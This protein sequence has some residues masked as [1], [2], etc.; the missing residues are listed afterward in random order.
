MLDNI[1]TEIRVIKGVH[2][3]T[4][5]RA[6]LPIYEVQHRNFIDL[7]GAYRLQDEVFLISEYV[8]F[9][10]K[11]ILHSD[12]HPTEAEIAYIIGQVRHTP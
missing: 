7:Y 12:I 4:G 6:Q 5:N 11:E 3:P 2:L 9:S 1:G 8:P 10:V